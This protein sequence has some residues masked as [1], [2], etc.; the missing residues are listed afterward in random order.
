MTSNEITPTAPPAGFDAAV[1]YLVCRWFE[2]EGFASD[3]D[4]LEAVD[5]FGPLSP[6]DENDEAAFAAYCAA[7]QPLYDALD[8]WWTEDF[9]A[10]VRVEAAARGVELAEAAS[11]FDWA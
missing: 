7:R 2:R 10:A 6:A 1:S 3:S 11:A 9:E 5:L 8:A 4:L